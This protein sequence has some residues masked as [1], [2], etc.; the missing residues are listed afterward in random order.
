MIVTLRNREGKY[1]RLFLVLEELDNQK[2]D[3]FVRIKRRKSR[4]V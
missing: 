4:K 3:L 1:S 2:Y